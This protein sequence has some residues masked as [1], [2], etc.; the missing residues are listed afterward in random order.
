MTEENNKIIEMAR[1]TKNAIEQNLKSL[2][3]LIKQNNDTYNSKEKQRLETLK[4]KITEISDDLEKGMLALVD[5]Q[6]G[7]TYEALNGLR[8]VLTNRMG[9]FGEY[10]TEMIGQEETKLVNLNESSLMN[11]KDITNAHFESVNALILQIGEV[12][13]DIVKKPIELRRETDASIKEELSQ[14]MVFE[15]DELKSS[16]TTLQDEY[17]EKLGNQMEKVFMG[18]TLTKEGINEII[19]DTLSRLEENLQRLTKGLDAN[20][21]TEVGKTQ[22]IFHEY[23][24]KMLNAISAMHENYETQMNRILDKHAKLTSDSLNGLQGS[25]NTQ[26]D[27]ILKQIA[28]LSE[29]QKNLVASA[30]TQLEEK[31]EESRSNVIDFMGNLRDQLQSALNE[32]TSSTQQLIKEFQDENVTLTENFS[33]KV[34]ETAKVT[35]EKAKNT[36]DEAKKESDIYSKDLKTVFGE[37]MNKSKG[38]LKQFDR[39]LK[40]EEKKQ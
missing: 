17:R 36:L 4:I 13:E 8:E 1:E 6:K 26:K 19:K 18:V 16:I 23:E 37:E 11:V 27:A 12:A 2:E 21:T 31:V 40:D 15:R 30:V 24:G 32:N 33:N 39:V 22:D 29:E 3:D 35:K 14:A 10:A 34:T 38:N 25:L 7:T 5:T 28:S 20:F 9:G